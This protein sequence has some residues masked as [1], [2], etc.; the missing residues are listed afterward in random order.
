MILQHLDHPLP[1]QIPDDHPPIAAPA[2]QQP[3]V[4]ANTQ[5]GRMV[6]AADDALD[7]A[8]GEVPFAD[9]FVAG[10]SEEDLGASGGG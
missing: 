4:H 10:T 8:R 1:N 5:H 6:E 3:V 2:R 7:L 9:R